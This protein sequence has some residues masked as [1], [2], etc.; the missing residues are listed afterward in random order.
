KEISLDV[1][2]DSISVLIKAEENTKDIPV[3]GDNLFQRVSRTIKDEMSMYMLKPD[4][5]KGQPFNGVARFYAEGVTGSKYAAQIEVEGGIR[6]SKLIL[7]AW[8]EKEDALT[9]F[10]YRILDEI[11]KRI[12]VKGYI[13]EPI[14]QNFIAGHLITGQVGKIIDVGDKTIQ[15]G[16]LVKDSVI[17]RSNIGASARKC[18]NCGREV[19]AN[20]KFCLECGARL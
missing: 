5:T 14:I 12:D 16:T 20:E 8:A 6:K 2:R 15:V 11:E 19:E 9:G 10:Y 17:Q 7:Q 1:W 3:A 13:D 4:V 18:P